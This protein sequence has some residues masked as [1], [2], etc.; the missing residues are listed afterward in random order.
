[1]GW[2]PRFGS[3]RIVHPFILALNFVTFMGILSP[4]LRRNVVYTCWPSLFLIFL[5]FTNFILGILSF[6][7]NIHL[8]VSAYLGTSVVIGLPH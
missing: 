3:L 8:S 2:I 4:I 1:M 6:S 5:C 7:A